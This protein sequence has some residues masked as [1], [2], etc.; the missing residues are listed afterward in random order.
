VRTVAFIKDAVM[1]RPHA[2]VC[3][4][5]WVAAASIVARKVVALSRGMYSHVQT[6][7]TSPAGALQMPQHGVR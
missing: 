3:A 7:S 4:E 5:K 6:R 1:G 2:V